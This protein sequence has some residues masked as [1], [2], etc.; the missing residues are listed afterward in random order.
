MAAFRWLA[1][2][3]WSRRFSF[4][5]GLFVPSAPMVDAATAAGDAGA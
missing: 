1:V 2:Q 5:L 3:H 4:Q